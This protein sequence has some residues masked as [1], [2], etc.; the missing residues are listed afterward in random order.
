MRFNLHMSCMRPQFAV[1]CRRRRSA[2]LNLDDQHAFRWQAEASVSQAALTGTSPELNL[3]RQSSL[4]DTAGAPPQRRGSTA[5]QQIAAAELIAQHGKKSRVNS[6]FA[7][8][9]SSPT[10]SPQVL[11]WAVV[12]LP[13][14][15]L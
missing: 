7:Q 5:R 10:S 9:D 11:S 8:D 12:H 1:L 13:L 14:D 6:A 3:T 15:P 4:N 2:S